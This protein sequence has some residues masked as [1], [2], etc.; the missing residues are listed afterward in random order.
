MC[1]QHRHS[2]RNKQWNWWREE[3]RRTSVDITD[4]NTCKIWQKLCGSNVS[5]LLL[6]ELLYKG[7]N[8]CNAE[9]I[10]SSK[11]IQKW[12]VQLT[13]PG[14][15]TLL[16]TGSLSLPAITLKPRLGQTDGISVWRAAVFKLLFSFSVFERAAVQRKPLTDLPLR[17]Y[18][19]HQE[20][21]SSCNHPD[22]CHIAFKQARLLGVEC[23]KVACK[24]ASTSP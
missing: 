12:G 17:L 16:G 20:L 10:R 3:L 15:V 2:S 6:S 11:I 1:H 22:W 18:M 9:H 8:A 24:H 13:L 19:N 21:S 7:A 14:Q 23:L 4:K 5:E